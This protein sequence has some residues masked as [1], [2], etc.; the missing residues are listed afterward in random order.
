MKIIK[1]ILSILFALIIFH[2]S[3]QVP[4]NKI[5][6]EEYIDQ[7]KS[8]AIKE[9]EL[10][11]IPAS[12]TLAQG[13]LESANGN[14]ALARNAN[15][16]F[17]I[18]CHKGWNG[19]TY[20]MDDDAKDECFRKYADPFESFKDH[21]IFLSTR[22]RYA[23]LFALEITDYKGWA[24][25]LKKAGY[26]TN[27]KYPQLL[28]KIIE[29]YQ[30]YKYDDPNYQAIAKNEN[31][32]RKNTQSSSEDFKSI[33]IGANNRAIFSNNGVKFIYARKGDNFYNIARDFNIYT[34]QVFRYNDLKKKD[35]VY[36]GQVI[37]L[38]K[39]KSKATQNYHIVEPGETLYE[40][41]QH[42]AIR[43]NKLCKYNSLD[44]NAKL[45]PDQKLK[46]RK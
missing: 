42:Y 37:Y 46:L 32:K 39:K 26:A 19:K 45:F 13:I 35:H 25:G 11:H 4:G 22:D 28:I 20:H 43:L 8:I 40:I 16:H 14:S 17:G 36:E 9:M 29:D 18:K 6:R 10:F 34:W 23:F 21:S 30:L 33:T 12:I 44:K 41:S 2:L 1:N 15:N 24:R 27:P 31:T 5:S 3:A 7:Y 38:E